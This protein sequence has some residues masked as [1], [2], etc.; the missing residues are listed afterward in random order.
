MLQINFE[1]QKYV[2]VGYIH[3]K[4]LRR[5]PIIFL[6]DIMRN[7]LKAVFAKPRLCMIVFIIKNEG[8]ERYC[9]I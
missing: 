4:N 5:K 2:T 7:S 1:A 9:S 6:F 8:A 3:N